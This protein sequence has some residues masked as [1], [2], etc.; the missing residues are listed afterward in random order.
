MTSMNQ[1]PT[2][3]AAAAVVEAVGV[4]GEEQEQE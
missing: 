3:P 4:E 2:N 1:E